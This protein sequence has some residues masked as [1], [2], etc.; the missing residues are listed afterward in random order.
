MS[1]KRSYLK[2]SR[3]PMRRGNGFKKPSFAE[4]Y[5]QA[6]KKNGKRKS[7]RSVVRDQADHYFS[8]FIRYRDNWTCQRCGGKYEP[9]TASLQCSHFYGRAR[10]NT[11]FD[12]LNADSQCAGC[13]NF[14]GAN[15]ELHREWKLQRIGEEDYKK[16]RIRAELRCKKDRKLQAMIAKKLYEDEKNRFES[17]IGLTP[18]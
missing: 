4:A 13:H 15:P 5:D 18:A 12:P 7:F 17:E 11:R 1:L 10:E 14:L 6:T 16:L 3:K 8:L 9:V 2:S